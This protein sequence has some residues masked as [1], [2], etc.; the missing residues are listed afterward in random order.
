MSENNWYH[1]KI[2]PLLTQLLSTVNCQLSIVNSAKPLNSNFSIRCLRADSPG[3]SLP[4]T[5]SAVV[6]ELFSKKGL[7]KPFGWSKIAPTFIEQGSEGKS[8]PV[9]AVQRA[10]AGGKGYG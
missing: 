10:P 4:G 6:G 9:D 5:H 1:F 2:V 3:S 8:K 7:T